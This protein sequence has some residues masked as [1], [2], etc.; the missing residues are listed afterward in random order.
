MLE[1][2]GYA[3]ATA[4]TGEEGLDLARSVMPSLIT[5]DVLMPGMDGWAVLREL[6]SNPD[7]RHIPVMMVSVTSDMDM[8]Y[9]LGAVEHLTKPVDRDSLRELVGKYAAPSGGGHAL[10]VDDEANIRSL[11]RRT[12]EGDGWTVA[13]AANGVDALERVAEQR[14]RIILLDLMM[15]VMD[16]FDFLLR[17]RGLEGCESTPIIVI[18]AK[19]LSEEERQLL[20]GGVE[21]IIEK[22][23]LTREELLAHVR[24]LVA[25]HEAPSQD[26]AETAAPG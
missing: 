9:S 22:G 25:S 14:P 23:G 1:S 3:V 19:D 15:P 8:G 12:L 21:R 18:T 2:E 7:L 26:G 20:A 16:G 10:V 13:E 4:S 17:Y 24:S 11:F 6:K 5:L